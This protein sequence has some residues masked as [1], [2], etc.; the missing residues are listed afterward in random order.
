MALSSFLVPFGMAGLAIAS[1]GLWTVR[2]SLAARGRKAAGAFVAA[3]E[4]LVFVL[5]FTRLAADLDS[6]G[7]LVGYGVGVAV[8]TLVGLVLDERMSGGQ[9]EIRVAANG[10]QPGLA[11]AL[12]ERGWPATCLSADGP[13]GPVTLVFVAADDARMPSLTDDVRRIAP[14]AFWTVHRLGKTHAT[15]LPAGFTQVRGPRVKGR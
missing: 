5:A 11:T 14:D 15:P 3:I 13:S 9:S 12:H 1:V 10:Y 7:R 2:V 4:A 8:G 6:P